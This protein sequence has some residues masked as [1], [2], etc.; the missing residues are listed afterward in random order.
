MRS[1]WRLH[2][3]FKMS[4]DEDAAL[5]IRRMK[6]SVSNASVNLREWTYGEA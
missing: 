6:Q 5:N 2:V 3:V 1:E 4:N